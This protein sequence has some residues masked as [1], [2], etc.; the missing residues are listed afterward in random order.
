GV[1]GER[2]YRGAVKVFSAIFIVIGVAVLATTLAAGGGPASVGFLLGLAF[3]A[4]GA[5]RFWSARGGE[6]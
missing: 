3:L 4:I 5:V 6:R 2:A 1:S